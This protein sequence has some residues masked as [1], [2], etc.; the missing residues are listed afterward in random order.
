MHLRFQ[1]EPTQA[2]LRAKTRLLSRRAKR[3]QGRDAK[4][5]SDPGTTQALASP[6]T[7]PARVF[8]SQPARTGRELGTV[9]LRSGIEGIPYPRFWLGT[10]Y[11]DWP[12]YG[13]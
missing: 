11:E 13:T 8:R 1:E 9:D 5:G 10:H 7:T 6:I 2:V 3:R 12:K 4:V